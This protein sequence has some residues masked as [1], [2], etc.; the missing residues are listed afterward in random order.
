MQ[1]ELGIGL[2]AVLAFG[3]PLMLFEV[4]LRRS[5]QRTDEA[6]HVEAKIVGKSVHLSWL[7]LRVSSERFLAYEVRREARGAEEP[8]FWSITD[9]TCLSADDD[10]V[11]GGE[12]YRYNIFQV[13]QGR[14]GL[15]MV[16]Q[17][18]VS[19]RVPD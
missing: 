15:D 14:G 17:N 19:I 11:K 10:G 9:P 2:L 8:V 6:F 3:L 16:V 13:A 5:S 12:V 18:S 1:T 4:S 7:P